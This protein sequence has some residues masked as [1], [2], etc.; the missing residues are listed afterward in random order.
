[1]DQQNRAFFAQRGIHTKS[2]TGLRWRGLI[3]VVS[4]VAIYFMLIYALLPTKFEAEVG[5][6]LPETVYATQRVQ[7]KITTDDARA[8]AAEQVQP[9][10]SA[11]AQVATHQ[12]EEFRTYYN[13]LINGRNEAFVRA[14]YNSAGGREL[15]PA[16]LDAANGAFAKPLS[17]EAIHMLLNYSQQDIYHQCTAAEQKMAELYKKGVSE[18]GVVGE[19]LGIVKSIPSEM[20][21]LSGVIGDALDSYF[22]ANLLYDEAATLNERQLARERVEPIYYAKGQVIVYG[23]ETITP[24]QYYVLNELGIVGD[25]SRISLSAFGGTLIMVMSILLLYYLYLFV[26]RKKVYQSLKYFLL[27]N[28]ILI[29]TIGMCVLALG[30]REFLMP[31]A[32]GGFLATTLIDK[33]TAV[34]TNLVICGMIGLVQRETWSMFSVYIFLISGTV[35]IYILAKSRTR[36][37]MIK[38]GVVTGAVGFVLNV[39]Y[40]FIAQRSMAIS[41]AP[42]LYSLGNTAV[43]TVLC[44]GFTLLFEGVFHVLTPSTL[45]DLGNTENKIL[46]D[47]IQKAPGTYQHSVTVGTLAENAADVIGEGGL[48]AR[49]ASYYH[50]IGKTNRPEYFKENQNSSDNIHDTLAPLESAKIIIDHV[51]DG[52]ALAQRERLPKEISDVILQH[53]G[54][55]VARY[56]YDKAN[57][58]GGEVNRDDYTY[59]GPKP[60]SKVSAI[61]MLADTLEAVMRLG[62]EEKSARQTIIELIYDKIQDGQLDE[63]ELSFQDIQKIIESFDNTFKAI[64]HKRIAYEQTGSRA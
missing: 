42:A 32:L 35:G 34:M 26:F 49:I 22:V 5:G 33:K 17:N 44:V 56:F 8:R 57:K 20:Q 11:S 52:Y 29:L 51:S 21:G 27:I 2:K 30:W 63:C 60:Q 58:A 62:Y 9:Q 46:K 43:A 45:V 40:S 6:A 54:T 31:I 48:L 53:H 4:V 61:I 59:P 25:K 50:D 37:S 41:Y 64:Y 39:A 36:F 47:L 14:T 23:G 28:A 55:T 1:M 19:R 16:A 12:L 38:A 13:A 7:D 18:Q 15:P 10:Y 3:A 24:A